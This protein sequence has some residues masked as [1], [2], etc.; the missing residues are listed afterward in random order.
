MQI[1]YRKEKK[2]NKHVISNLDLIVAEINLFRDTVSTELSKISNNFKIIF[3]KEMFT[4]SKE[5]DESSLARLSYE[6]VIQSVE[7]ASPPKDS[8]F[9]IELSKGIFIYIF[10]FRKYSLLL[11][12]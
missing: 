6:V 10:L 7:L 1:N 12:L 4:E 9:S 8:L 5:L 2:L 11:I 3:T